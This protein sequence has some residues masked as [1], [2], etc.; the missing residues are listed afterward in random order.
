MGDFFKKVET[1]ETTKEPEED[2]IKDFDEILSAFKIIET[3]LEQSDIQSYKVMTPLRVNLFGAGHTPDDVGSVGLIKRQMNG[4][5]RTL[6]RLPIGGKMIS[7][8]NDMDD[9]DGWSEEYSE[10]K[11]ECISELKIIAKS[12]FKIMDHLYDEN[13]KMKE[14]IE[15]M[16]RPPSERILTPMQRETVEDIYKDCKTPLELGNWINPRM[17]GKK[18]LPE[19]R[20]YLQELNRKWQK[21]KGVDAVDRT[22]TQSQVKKQ[23]EHKKE[24]KSTQ[25][26]SISQN[27]PLKN[28]LSLNED[29]ITPHSTKKALK[30][31]IEKKELYGENGDNEKE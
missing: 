13:D 27:A 5:H 4:I 30:K 10:Y 24:I 16:E 2:T 9:L 25:T 3:K 31:E 21:F 22:K 1:K 8:L 26:G 19:Q 23:A 29:R 20:L 12:C 28:P 15:D 14:K 18:L 11:E 6:A 7:I 17:N